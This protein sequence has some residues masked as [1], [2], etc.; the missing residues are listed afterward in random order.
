MAPGP[1]GGHAPR[2]FRPSAF[3]RIA[4]LL[5]EAS[6]PAPLLGV[7]R[8]ARVTGVLTAAWLL[9]VPA[10]FRVFWVTTGAWVTGVPVVW[11]LRVSVT[12]TRAVWVPAVAACA[13]RGPTGR[14]PLGHGVPP[15]N[16]MN[17]YQCTHYGTLKPA[18]H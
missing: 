9:R 1:A 16:V 10:V 4:R 17:Q 6:S 5:G 11:L 8:A 15:R 3:A 12:A 18:R 2:T 14:V 7:C 13:G